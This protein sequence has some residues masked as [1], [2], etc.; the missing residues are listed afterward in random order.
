[1]LKCLLSCE[2][3]YLIDSIVFDEKTENN[4]QPTDQFLYVMLL[5]TQKM[6]KSS[7]TCKKAGY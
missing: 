5:N 2:Y 3:L 7:I 4:T 6:G 1:M